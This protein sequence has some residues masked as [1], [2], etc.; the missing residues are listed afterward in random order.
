MTATAL[1]KEMDM[2]DTPNSEAF[3]SS[4]AWQKVCT[5]DD[6]VAFSGIAAW[7][8]TADGPPRSPFSTCLGWKTAK[9]AHS[10]PSTTMTLSLTPM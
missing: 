1:K 7:L 4:S 8:E 10:M 5:K 3:E 6:L 2:V 9:T